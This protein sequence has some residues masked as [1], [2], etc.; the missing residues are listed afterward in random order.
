MK[1]INEARNTLINPIS[2]AEYDLN[3]LN[4][5]TSQAHGPQSYNQK[6]SNVYVA[7]QAV[8]IGHGAR[9]E[10]FLGMKLYM[11]F[12]IYNYKD[13]IGK[14]GYIAVSDGKSVTQPNSN[15]SI[16][17]TAEFTAKSNYDKMTAKFFIYYDLFPLEYRT[18]Q[19]IVG[20]S[21]EVN[22]I[23]RNDT[24]IFDIDRS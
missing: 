19:I 14:C 13:R 15:A 9:M 12:E 1:Y 23:A 7:I 11:D 3:R 24:L 10:R 21:D 8:Y 16:G 6:Q 2:R 5:S 22:V 4:N 17:G 18:Y 20:V